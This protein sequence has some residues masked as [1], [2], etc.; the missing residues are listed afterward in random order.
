MLDFFQ[1]WSDVALLIAT[2]A[3]GAVAGRYVS[4]AA[5]QFI[6]ASREHVLVASAPARHRWVPPALAALFLLLTWR[7]GDSWALPAYLFFAAAGMLLALVDVTH[8]LLP[9]KILLRAG[10]IGAA[11]LVL[12]AALDD[13]WDSLARA[14]AGGLLLFAVYLILALLPPA[15][16]GMGDVKFSIVIGMFLA[17]RSWDVLVFGSLA[18][19]V[20]GGMVSAWVLLSRHGDSSG[21][22]AFGPSMLLGA[23]A[24]LALT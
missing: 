8:Q 16:L 7:L 14:A 19:F 18:G 13:D 3:I 23:M 20:V 12:A 24:A 5:R 1:S 10:A 11:L 2:T 15:S 21:K 6:P 4:S 17:F 9:N 22:V